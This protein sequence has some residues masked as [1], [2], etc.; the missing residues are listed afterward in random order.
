MG[1]T[2]ESYSLFFFT[3]LSFSAISFFVYAAGC[4]FSLRMK[5]EFVRYGFDRHRVLI[6]GLQLLGAAGLLLGLIVPAIGAIG[7]AGLAVQMLAA[8]VVRI[9]IRDTLLQTTP[10]LVYLLTNALLFIGFL[11]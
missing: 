7:A 9:K 4:F 10:A 8:V 2:T 5:A 3:L 1:I 6:G 11:D